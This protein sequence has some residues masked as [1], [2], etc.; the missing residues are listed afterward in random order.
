MTDWLTG[1]I[2]FW[3]MVNDRDVIDLS[4]VTGEQK[5]TSAKMSFS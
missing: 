1:S 2:A 3:W 4:E 5:T